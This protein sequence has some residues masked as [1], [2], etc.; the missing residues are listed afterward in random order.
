MVWAKRHHSNGTQEDQMQ[1]PL[2]EV[3]LERIGSALESAQSESSNVTRESYHVP[4]PDP[5]MSLL[6]F[7]NCSRELPP[8]GW[9]W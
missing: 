9:I 6:N 4:P 5:R 7:Q 2:A 1:N 3:I 8:P